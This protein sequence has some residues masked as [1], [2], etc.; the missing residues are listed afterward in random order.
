M[1]GSQGS[2]GELFARFT[3]QISKLFRA[4]IALTKAQA[5]AAAQR[6]AAA[7]I[8]LVAALVLALYM[9]GWLI[10]AMFLSWQLAVPSWAA[11]LLTAAVLAVLAVILGV[12]GYAALKKAQRHLP[13]PTEGVKTDVGIIKSAFKPTTEEDR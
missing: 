4:E 12:A 2:L 6:F 13:N 7:G 8:L 10:H 9:L 3:T 1:P 11:A 5:K